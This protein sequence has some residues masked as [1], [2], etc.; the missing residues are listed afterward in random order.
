MPRIGAAKLPRSDLI[1]ARKTRN[2]TPGLRFACGF[3]P[4]AMQSC[5]S[6]SGRKARER[7]PTRCF[8]AMVHQKP[9]CGATRLG[10]GTLGIM[11]VSLLCR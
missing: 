4:A 1:R 7:M 8:I 5:Q 3:P 10:I 6:R 9:S 11:M 2:T